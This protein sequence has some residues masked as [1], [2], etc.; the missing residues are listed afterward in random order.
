MRFGTLQFR[1]SALVFAFG[2]F[3]I[4]ISFTRQYFREVAAQRNAIRLAAYSEGARLSGLA[5]HF[6][7][8]QLPQ[9]ADLVISYASVNPDLLHAVI[10]DGADVVRHAAE[11]QWRGLKLQQTPLATAVPMLERVREKMEARIEEI[12]N[13]TRMM[14][15]FPFWDVAGNMSKGMVIL[16][17]DLRGPMDAAKNRILHHSVAEGCALFGGCFLLWAL[18]HLMVTERVMKIVEQ[19]QRIG[20]DGAVDEPIKGP[21]ELAQVSESIAGAVR[22]L[23]ATEQRF[24]R[25]AASIRD[26]FWMAGAVRREP[27][28]VNPAYEQELGLSVE[29]LTTHRWEWLHR[30]VKEDR[31]KVLEMLSRLRKEPGEMDLEIRI[32]GLNGLR[33]MNC[34]SFSVAG[35]PAGLQLAG[36]LTDITERKELERQV[37][38]VAEQERRRIGQDLHDDVCQRLAAA[39]L[40]TG[41]LQASLARADL[42]QAKL[43]RDVGQ[44]LAETTDIARRFANGLAPVAVGAEALPQALR[45]LATFL[46]RAFDIACSASCDPVGGVIAAE[47]AAQIYR[48]AQELSTNA[49]KHSGGTWIDISLAHHERGLR[50]EIS[51]DGSAFDPRSTPKTL[52]MGIRMVQQRVDALGASLSFESQFEPNGTTAVCEIPISARS[53]NCEVSTP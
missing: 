26:V 11:Q 44:E 7:R 47:A 33:W 46:Q 18:L 48:I 51:H 28:Y 17:Y 39:N 8:R 5:Q 49:A 35:E 24:R 45:E 12:D 3:T 9:S 42:P 14:A 50:L 29:R 30:V 38:E 53:P 19:T 41:V 23:H 34:R 40:K 25:I 43:A 36:V 13:G 27:V 22:R 6:L 2:I 20:W 15:V 31:R 1:L 52:G 16:A 32:R 21:D 37:I 10:C 4:T